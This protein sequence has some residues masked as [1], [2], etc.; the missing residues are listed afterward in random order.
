MQNPPVQRAKADAAAASGTGKLAGI[1]LLRFGSALAVLLWHYQHFSFVANQ[2]FAFQTEAQ[3]L[4]GL[5]SLF[6]RYGLYGVQVFWCISGLIFFWKYGQALADKTVGAGRFFLLRF[7]RLYPLH[8]IT[9]LLVAGGQALYAS[10]HSWY[11]VYK[12]NS[13]SSFFLQLGMT[14]HWFFPRTGFSF[15][16]PIWS[17]SLEVIAYLFFF[18]FSRVAGVG[19]LATVGALAAL[20]LAR[21]ASELPVIECLLFF[22]LGGVLALL[23]RR[24][25]CWS[26]VARHGLGVAL[27]VALMGLC[28]ATA[29]GA[30]KPEHAIFGIVPVMVYLMLQYVRPAHAGVQ[31]LFS[32]L[33][34]L[35][36][37]SYLLHFP[38]Q[39]AIALVCGALG[40]AIPWRS[41]WLLLGFLGMTLV[42]SFFCYRHVERPLQAWIRAL[43]RPGALGFHQRE[44][45][46]RARHALVGARNAGPQ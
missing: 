34:N 4:F 3:P 6:Y 29:A 27:A 40:R 20:G 9:L 31:K 5:L 33:G 23:D 24:S 42:L 1:D 12:D 36:Y 7:S 13:L 30:I 37:S 45:L 25:A 15:N 41:P 19:A 44:Y 35:T 14:S 39:L 28:A 46:L 2:G 32:S 38:L 8:L 18:C 21:Y 43:G 26:A 10:T 22:Y 11:F 17:V 16:A